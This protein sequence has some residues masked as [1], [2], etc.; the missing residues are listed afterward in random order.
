[1]L[2][3][4][5]HLLL[6]SI[7]LALA[8]LDQ[9]LGNLEDV[10]RRPWQTCRHPVEKCLQVASCPTIM[11]QLRAASADSSLVS[12]T[13][14]ALRKKICGSP[15]GR[16]VCCPSRPLGR[17]SE[18]SHQVRGEVFSLDDSTLLI[19]D[20]TYDGRGPDSFF[21][22]STMGSRP[23]SLGDVVLPLRHFSVHDSLQ[24]TT[25]SSPAVPVRDR[26]IE[27]LPAF[28]RQ[29]I[30]LR[31]PEGILVSQLRWLSVWCREFQVDFGHVVFS[32]AA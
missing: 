2:P 8:D 13:V 16:M 6:A 4:V 25:Y 31:L 10:E 7:S 9:R 26:D 27:I 19:E 1:M 32:H 12:E 29:D 5:Q 22:A 18:L 15:S 21:L 11:A 23:S 28:Y 17:L 30:V 24:D 3:A 20:F 14:S